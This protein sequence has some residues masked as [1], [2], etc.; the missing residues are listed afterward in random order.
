MD[1]LVFADDLTGAY[2]IA[3]N[4]RAFS[5]TTRVIWEKSE[6]CDFDGDLVICTK[7]R[8]K[9][10][11]ESRA[12]LCEI[13]SITKK[14]CSPAMVYMKV[15]SMLRGNII[16]DVVGVCTVYDFDYVVIDIAYP[17]L[18]RIVNDA[19]VF[20]NGKRIEDTDIVYDAKYS[21]I[22]V[23][24]MDKLRNS[25]HGKV[26]CLKP[27]EE[28]NSNNKVLFYDTMKENDFIEIIKKIQRINARVLW[29]GSIGLY[30]ALLKTHYKPQ[31]VFCVIGSVSDLSEQQILKAKSEETSLVK[32]NKHSEQIE[33]YVQQILELLKRG[34]NV[35]LYSERIRNQSL[36]HIDSIIERKCSNIYKIAISVIDEIKGTNLIVSGGE[37]AMNILTT[38]KNKN[39]CIVGEIE[40][41]VPLLEVQ[42]GNAK[43]AVLIKSG[44][45]GDIEALCRHIDFLRKYTVA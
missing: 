40:K 31:N 11:L 45:V 22:A 35:I 7:T 20:I 26:Q 24:F 44:R 21:P 17:Q 36:P 14:N 10:S 12:A 13:A 29:V 4:G 42:D 23:G 15:D 25:F 32:I 28:V 19:E 8:E 16:E 37:T 33:I 43:Y 5:R 38:Q 41:S 18:G 27:D 1:F 39:I 30:L 3:V 2:D 34:K 9:N 6:I